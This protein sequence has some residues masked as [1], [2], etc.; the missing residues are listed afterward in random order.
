M[1]IHES[2]LKGCP[3]R[4]TATIGVC[5]CPSPAWPSR[6]TEVDTAEAVEVTVPNFLQLIQGLGEDEQE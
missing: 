6:R 3:V 1:I 5:P 2:R 4:G